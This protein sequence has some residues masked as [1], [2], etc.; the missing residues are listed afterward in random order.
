MLPLP[1]HRHCSDLPVAA[2]LQWSVGERD[3][4][5]G[6]LMCRGGSQPALGPCLRRRGPAPHLAQPVRPTARASGPALPGSFPQGLC[7]ALGSGCG[8]HLVL[9]P[10]PAKLLG[11]SAIALFCRE[12]IVL[13]G[14][15]LRWQ[16]AKLPSLVQP[17]VVHAWCAPRRPFASL[18]CL[19]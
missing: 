11:V 13:R 4:R 8:P 15:G 1:R 3:A 12:A 5:A 9:L 19:D 2:L 17:C 18:T 10:N 6:E 7:A 14:A 16:L